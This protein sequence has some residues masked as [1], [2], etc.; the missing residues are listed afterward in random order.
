MKKIKNNV[1]RHVL[2]LGVIAVIA[3]F[4]LKVFLGG[5][6]ADVEAY[7]PFG[8]LQSLA[9]FISSDTL[10]CSM[11]VVQITMGIVLA[12][13]VML[14]SKLFCGY[15]CPLGTLTEWMNELRKKMKIGFVVKTGSVGDKLLRAIKYILLFVIFY[16]TIRSSELFCKNF[17]PYY[18]F[19]TGFKGEL[20]AWMAIISILVLF[21][22][23]LFIGMFWCKYVCPLGALS[24]IFKFTL[25][26]IVLVVLGIIAGYAG[27]PM[28]W[29]W[30]LGAAAVICYL[31]EIIYYKSNTF[32][33]LR[34][35]RKEEK[36]NNC[37]LCSKRC[38]MNIDVAQLKTV[39]HV[40]CMLCGECVGVCHS[41][42]IQINRNPRFRWLPVVL[43]VVL[44]FFA[45]WMGSHWELPT[46]SEK[47]GDEAKW[48]KLEMFERDGMKTVKCYGSSKA[49]AAK[50]K[51]VPGVYGVTTY[52][53]RFAVQVYYNPE[54]TTQEKVEKAMF[55]PTKMKLKVPSPEV[56]KLQVITIG[57]EKLFDK[58]DVTFLSNIFRQKEGYYG[59]ISQYACPVQIKLFIDANKPIDKK[60]L[61]EIVE[62]REFEILLHGGV[63]KKVTC[64]YE[65]VSMDAKIDTISRADFLNLMFPQ[66]KMTFKG[67]VAKYGSDVATAVYELPYV[68]LDKPLIQRRLPYFGSFI[69]N[70]DGIL[71]YETAL[72]GDTPVIRITYVMEVL[73]D[74]KIGEM[75][76]APK[77]TIH[78][79]DG[80]V[81]EKEAQLP[82]KTPGKT[83]E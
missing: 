7:C 16:M 30:I 75:F 17:D 45:V 20:T 29:I 74:E 12:L 71:G 49:F 10:A 42:A 47:W 64:D 68:G 40:D 28:N 81:E 9:T 19:A 15:V 8:G 3:G 44:F 26:F 13:A 2:Q 58:M 37:G 70:Y 6:P 63:K 35:T 22:G 59:I 80:R 18:A 56:E 82:F 31:Y 72:N 46:I 27:L 41:Q 21:A 36:C 77:W 50:M 79:T 65:F 43:T 62:T 60:E 61:R 73:N 66:T 38:P 11:S 14:F 24:N 1:W 52:V 69:S 55:T 78:Y 5:A 32:P 53:N 83:I 76:Q 57:V 51:R 54:E 25:T 34:I 39:K 4:I 67:N 23:N 48:S 33:L